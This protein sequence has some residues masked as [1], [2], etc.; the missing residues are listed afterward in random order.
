M[1]YGAIF[2]DYLLGYLLWNCCVLYDGLLNYSHG[3]NI[4]LNGLFDNY[5]W[6]APLVV[7]VVVVIVVDDL[8]LLDV[9]C[10]ERI[11][12]GLSQLTLIHATVQPHSMHYQ[13]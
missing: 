6:L 7:V 11:S 10:L 13:I 9:L 1:G 4:F 5:R 12:Q 3:S 2:D 8:L